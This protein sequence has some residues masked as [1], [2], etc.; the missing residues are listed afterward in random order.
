MTSLCYF[1]DDMTE[2]THIC[3]Y[4][5]DFHIQFNYNLSGD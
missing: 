2:I 4:G 3:T 5:Y 1:A